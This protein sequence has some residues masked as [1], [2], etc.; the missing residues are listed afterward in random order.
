MAA[1]SEEYGVRAG[2]R[3][4]AGAAPIVDAELDSEASRN[5]YPFIT[6][7]H[8]RGTTSGFN[9]V[10]D[11]FIIGSQETKGLQKRKNGMGS[12]PTPFSV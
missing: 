7:N 9:F 12:K 1:R 4:A 5:Q 6:E 2:G 8:C 11:Y 3:H 10:I